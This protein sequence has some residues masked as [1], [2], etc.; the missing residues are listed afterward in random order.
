ML[1][2][3]LFSLCV[4]EVIKDLWVQKAGESVLNTWK[5]YSQGNHDLQEA[6][7]TAFMQ[8]AVTLALGLAQQKQ[9]LSPKLSREFAEVM[10]DRYIKPFCNGN[11]ALEQQL[12]Q[13]SK[14]QCK[15]LQTLFAE[16]P[17]PRDFFAGGGKSAV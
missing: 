17:I 2:P 6:L 1:I 13:V 12:R 11:Q 7:K 9:F 10:N 5:S 3:T 4:G 8:T 14:A 16:L 15:A